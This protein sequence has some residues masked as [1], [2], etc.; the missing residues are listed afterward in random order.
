M[1]KILLTLLIGFIGFSQENIQDL[2]NKLYDYDY[3]SKI[4]EL[5]TKKK[6]MK[7]NYVWYYSDCSG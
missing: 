4:E 5:G 7:L 6:S 2:I 3:Q 1:K